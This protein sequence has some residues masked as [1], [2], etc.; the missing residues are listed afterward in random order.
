MPRP[1]RRQI[2]VASITLTVLLLGTAVAVPFRADAAWQAMATEVAALRADVVAATPRRQPLWGEPGPGNAHEHYAAAMALAQT[3]GRDHHLEL[4][5][6]LPHRAAWQP[7][8][9]EAL[10]ARWQELLRHLRAG[11]AAT[12]VARSPAT[13]EAAN[14]LH[15]LIACRWVANAAVFEARA[16][17]HED[18]HVEAVR[19]SLDA[20]TFATDLLRHGPLVEQMIG[21]ARLAIA[22]MEAWPDTALAELDRA[23][24]DALAIGLRRLDESLPTT[25]DD[26]GELLFTAWHLT[27]AVGDTGWLPSR[28]DA[29]RFG[30]STRWLLADAFLAQTA[31]SERLA[32]TAEAPW[33]VRSAALD[34]EAAIAN[35]SGNPLVADF[36]PN[37]GN[38]ETSWREV[39]A[40][41]RLL[42]LAVDLHRGAPLPPLVDPIGGGTIT[43]SERDDVVELACE[44]IRD[45]ARVRRQVAR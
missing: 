45:P 39:L 11:A 26:R 41:L 29:W 17:R 31:R 13:G 5:A 3:L 1:T 33:A 19:W 21:C 18:R 24:L 38:A 6:L 8:G 34:R 28:A 10:R 20:A 32:A 23:G 15:S 2:L 30:F 22:T 9:H 35:A 43:V 14:D 7:A 27:H 12:D 40:H 36:L 37:L 16:L 25:L 42:R 4:V 44:A